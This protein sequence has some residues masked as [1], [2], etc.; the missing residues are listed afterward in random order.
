M[1]TYIVKAIDESGKKV[2]KRITAK[3]TDEL[4]AFAHYSGLSLVSFRPISK[5]DNIFNKKLK[6]DELVEILESLYLVV[7]SGIPLNTGLKEI[8]SDSLNCNVSDTLNMIAFRTEEGKSFSKAAESCGNIF[9]ET[10]LNLMR[11]GEETGKLEQTLKDASSHVSRIGDL[12]AKTLQAL[13]YPM[14]A[15]VSLLGAL[16]FWLAYVMPK[17]ADTFAV[18]DLELPLFTRLVMSASYFLQSY[19]GVVILFITAC[20]VALTYI[21]KRKP[22]FKLKADRALLKTPIFGKLLYSYNLAFFSE[23]LSLM[24]GAGLPLYKSLTV[25]ENGFTNLVFIQAVRGIKENVEKGESFATAMELQ[26]IFPP[27]L[28]RMAKVGEKTGH[29]TEQLS[30]AAEHYFTKTDRSARNLSKV[31][32][33]AIIGFVGLF[34]LIIFIGLLSPVFSLIGSVN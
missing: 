6:S 3:N 4:T 9:G 27:L 20:V 22:S 31:L 21:F 23:Y 29:L 25:M 12:K 5:L 30:T 14:L 8:A 15:V 16:I 24:T 7:K 1:T 28:V 18:F 2:R 19:F 32:E 26:E 33:P 17:M 11:I 34:M 10:V 13:L